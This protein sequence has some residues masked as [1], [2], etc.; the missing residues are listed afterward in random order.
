MSPTSRIN[1]LPTKILSAVV[2]LLP[3]R[4]IKHL[5]CVSKLLRKVCLPP[6]FRRVRF[7]FA[8]AGFEEITVLL[9]SDVRYY[10]VSFTYTVPKLLMTGTYRHPEF[11]LTPLTFCIEI[12][13]FDRFRSDIL[14]PNSYV[15]LAKAV[16]DEDSD[17]DECPLYMAIYKTVRSMCR[18][19]RNVVDEGADLILSSIFSTLPLLTEVRLSFYKVLG[20]CDRVL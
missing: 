12:R 1:N 3:L 17:E 15:D 20:R 8:L 18:E 6:L 7:R 13:D 14:T 11:A 19:Q 2:D 10:I 4:E 5:S 16:Y 9:K